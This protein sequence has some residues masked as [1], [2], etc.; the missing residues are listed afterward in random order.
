MPVI[1]YVLPALMWAAAAGAADGFRVRLP[2]LDFMI[3]QRCLMQMP[4]E[5]APA[6]LDGLRQQVLDQRVP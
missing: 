3:V 1:R 6:V 5:R 4:E 2:L